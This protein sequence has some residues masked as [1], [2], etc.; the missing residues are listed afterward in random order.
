M[1][2]YEQHACT[3]PPSLFV[4]CLT[5][6]YREPKGEDGRCLQ[7]D[8]SCTGSCLRILG[9]GPENMLSEI[10]TFRPHP[11]EHK[12]KSNKADAKRGRR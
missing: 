11:V 1:A 10:S 8:M 7:K 12:L 9:L 2:P 6:T 5:R 4:M 3:E